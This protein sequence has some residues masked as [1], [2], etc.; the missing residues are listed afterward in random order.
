M[1]GFS[2]ELFVKLAGHIQCTSQGYNTISMENKENDGHE[3]VTEMLDRL[4]LSETK[5]PVSNVSV[6]EHTNKCDTNGSPK[7]NV[8]PDK[9]E[10]AKNQFCAKV[11]LVNIYE[12]FKQ[13][14]YVAHN[15]H[16]T[17]LTE[18][19]GLN[20]D[21]LKCWSNVYAILMQVNDSWF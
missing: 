7:T 21:G 1:F 20:R 15:F 4:T 10:K 9:I 8:K 5:S 3:V 2:I 19:F 13:N 11:N 16:G 6:D 14:R 17:T 12:N 18:R